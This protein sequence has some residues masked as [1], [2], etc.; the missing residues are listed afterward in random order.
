VYAQS[1]Y[2]PFERSIMCAI[3]VLTAVGAVVASRG[4][5]HISNVMTGLKGVVFF[6]WAFFHMVGE[7][8]GNSPPCIWILFGLFALVDFL[9]IFFVTRRDRQ[10]DKSKAVPI[11]GIQPVA[12]PIQPKETNQV[13]SWLGCRSFYE[14]GQFLLL[15]GVMHFHFGYLQSTPRCIFYKDHRTIMLAMFILTAVGAVVASRGWIHISNVLTGLKGLVFCDWAFLPTFDKGDG[16]WRMLFVLFALVDFLSIFFLMR[17]D[18]QKSI[19]MPIIGI[20]S[21][22][23]PIQP[24]ATDDSVQPAVEVPVHV[25]VPIQPKATGD[26]A[27][28]VQPEVEV[29]V[30]V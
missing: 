17:K 3:F 11:I 18:R 20:Q 21:V 14:L 7:F 19:A 25:A 26:S 5:I 8:G 9:S 22:A 2:Y 30:Q 24:K 29:P 28:S 16:P 12:V 15:L 6:C 10:T 4:W 27:S 1:G 23:V 13:L